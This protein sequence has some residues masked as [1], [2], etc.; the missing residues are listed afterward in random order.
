[1]IGK[2]ISHYRILETLGAG[3]MGVVYKAQDTRLG[4]FV[5][6]KFLPEEYADDPQVRERFQREARAASALNH[7]NIC[8]IYDIGEDSGRVFIAMEFLDGVTLK[9]LVR[10]HCLEPLRLID[11]AV[12]VLDGLE[13]AHCEGI[14]HRDVK[15][16]NIFITRQ[17]RAKILDFGLAKITAPRHATAIAG[18]D[19]TRATSFGATTTG[20]G[21][22]GTMAYMSPEQALGKALDPRSDLFSFGV[23]MYEM[24]TGNAPFQGDTTGVLFLAIVQENPRP[25]TEVN[26]AVPEG[27]EHIITRCLEKDRERRYQ[28]AVEIRADLK[29]LRREL[30]ASR[31]GLVE[32]AI[33]DEDEFV[34]AAPSKDGSGSKA[35]QTSNRR[36]L[37]SETVAPSS[38]SKSRPAQRRW[39]AVAGLAL[40]VFVAAGGFLY[41]RAHNASHL[42]ERDTIVLADFANT[43]ADPIFDGTLRQALTVDL[44]QSPF[45]NIISDRVVAATLKEMGKPPGERLSRTVAR[46]VC[47][48]TNSQAYVAGSIGKEGDV[49]QLEVQ[50]T[51]CQNNQTIAKVGAVAPGRNQVLSALDKLD[52]KLRVELGES[53]PS[54]AQF[55]KS[56]PEATTTSLEG[57]QAYAKGQSLR[58]TG[59][60]PIPDLQRAVDLD[61]NFAL[62][63][64]ALGNAYRETRQPDLGNESY[65]R[66]YELRN[67]VTE[68]ERFTIEIYYYKYVTGETGKVEKACQDGIKAYPDNLAFYTYLGLSYLDAGQPDKAAAIFE[69]ATLLSPG[70]VVPYTNLMDAYILLDKWDEAKIVFDEARKRNLDNPAL[71]ENRYLVAFL[72]GDEAGMNEQ[73]EWAKGK[74]KAEAPLLYSASQTEA[75]HGRFARARALTEEAQS[76]A[77]G[78]EARRR[79][80]EYDIGVAWC[81]AEVGN[82]ALARQQLAKVPPS[83]V[84][85]DEGSMAAIALATA[86]DIDGANRLAEELNRKY[87]TDTRTQSYVLPTVRALIEL[88]QG[89]AGSAIEILQQARPFDLASGDFAFMLPTYTRG[90]AYLQ[91]GKGREAVAEFQMMLDHRGV[92]ANFVTG[93]L[94]HLQLGRAYALNGDTAQAKTA[95]QDFFAIWKN[96]DP[97]IPILKQAQAEYAA[98]SGNPHVGA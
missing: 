36:E 48:R 37:M 27:L 54:L 92:V 53:L 23:T 81:E 9:E 58:S 84:D 49:Y 33:D 70:N 11:I 74:L 45:L 17:G 1:M 22:L 41:R 43:T 64:T 79:V 62:A 51:N 31:P 28:D 57:L 80:S 55:N 87:P 5:A 21:V 72:E 2:T 96:A 75:F 52:E 24:A 50:A 63:Y 15:P 68:R 6:L 47:L 14:L 61:P 56:L 8:T 10:D 73:L 12:Q 71:R 95:Y 13:A 32:A 65:I 77:G 29:Q 3:G 91:L 34:P 20:R 69:R 85:R 90:L 7:P 25:V 44:G 35:R 82:L 19:D 98:L 89:H 30:R 59:D 86:G 42:S 88:K 94:A 18:A 46:E 83:G 66:A 93:A 78:N 16:A 26:P 60:D 97:D 40:I 39:V 38:T 4:R 76:A 67:R